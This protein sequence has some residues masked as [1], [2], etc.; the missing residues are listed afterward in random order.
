MGRKP[1]PYIAPLSEPGFSKKGGLKSSDLVAVYACADILCLIIIWI[2][3]YQII[4]FYLCVASSVL[5]QINWTDYVNHLLNVTSV[6]V[7]SSEQI[8]I[9]ESQFFNALSSLIRDRLRSSDG[10]VYVFHPKR[11]IHLLCS[12]AD[13]IISSNLLNWLRELLR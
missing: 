4:S 3:L 1:N 6:R 8:L 13:G 12:I 9:Y 11:N 10:R 7:N 5:C 2:F